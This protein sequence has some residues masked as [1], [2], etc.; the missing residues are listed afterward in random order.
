MPAQEQPIKIGDRIQERYPVVCCVSSLPAG[1][2]SGEGISERVRVPGFAFKRYSYPLEDALISSS[3]GD[4]E[5]KGERR[6]TPLVI[7]PGMEWR[8]APSPAGHDRSGGRFRL[9]FE[10]RPGCRLRGASARLPP[11]ET[12]AARRGRGADRTHGAR[13]PRAAGIPRR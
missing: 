5:I 7:G 6:A 2:P 11:A 1:M 13:G 4:F 10:W 9:A 3:Q 8:P 12:P